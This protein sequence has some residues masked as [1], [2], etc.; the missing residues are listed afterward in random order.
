MYAREGVRGLFKGNGV[1][2]LINAPFNSFEFFF[3]E[4]FKNN[5]FQVDHE[6]GLRFYQKF[7]CGGLAGLLATSGLYPFDLV[8]THIAVKAES[9]G[10]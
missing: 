6:K 10:P 5:I 4:F 7:A 9:F 8:K 2:C 3:Y 1:N